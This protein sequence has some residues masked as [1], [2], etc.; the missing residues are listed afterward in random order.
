[1]P[2]QVSLAHAAEE[3]R[4]LITDEGKGFDVGH[5]IHN[6]GL[7]LVN[8]RECVRQVKGFIQFTSAPGQGARIEVTGPLR[9]QAADA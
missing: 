2:I 5:A 7:G 4:L 1:M 3:I 9:H 8:M 6:G